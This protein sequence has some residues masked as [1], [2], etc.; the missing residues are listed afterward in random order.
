LSLLSDSFSGFW[1]S[2]SSS[3]FLHW[4]DTFKCFR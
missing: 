3:V 4:T 2:L 1:S